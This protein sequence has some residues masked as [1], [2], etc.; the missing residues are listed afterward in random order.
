M[1]ALFR[2]H[3]WLTSALMLAVLLTLF[4][5]GRFAVGAVYWAQ[6]RQDPI[7]GWMTVGY[8][9][10]SWQLD[11]REIDA[12]AGFPL[13]QGHPLTLEEIARQRG[14]PV[15]EIIAQAEAAVAK[16]QAAGRAP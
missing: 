13:P 9:G 5:A 2:R 4:F 10:R 8:I 15:A 6:H 12:V 1:R 16:L 3:P 14:V 11:P 7:S